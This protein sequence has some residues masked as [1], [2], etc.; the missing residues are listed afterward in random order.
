MQH[1]ALRDAHLVADR[2]QEAL[3]ARV[4]VEQATGIVAQGL[5]CSMDE[6]FRRIRAHAHHVG[7]HVGEVARALVDR[8]LAAPELRGSV[9]G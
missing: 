5:G 8:A 3:D 6:A 9:H 1:R 7:E 4:A 2:L